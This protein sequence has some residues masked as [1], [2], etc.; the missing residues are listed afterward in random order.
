MTQLTQGNGDALSLSYDQTD[1]LMSAS[2]SAGKRVAYTRSANGRV[3]AKVTHQLDPDTGEEAPETILYSA[4]GWALNEQRVPISQSIAL[5]GGVSL[6]VAADASEEQWQ[7]SSL[8]NNA[9]LTTNGL[10]EVLDELSLYSPYGEVL[11]AHPITMEG[12]PDTGFDGA[13]GV[14]TET[15]AIDINVMGDRVY[16][17]LLHS[18]TTLD[19]TFNGG[20]SP[21][22]YANAD[23]VNLN[24]P[25][26]NAP[27]NRFWKGAFWDVENPYMWILIGGVAMGLFTGGM[28]ALYG[29]NFY[30][31]LAL[32]T[33]IGAIYGFAAGFTY[34]MITTD[35]DW[36]ASLEMG[37]VGA[38]YGAGGAAVGYVLG[39]GAVTAY[40]GNGTRP[41]SSAGE[42]GEMVTGARLWGGEGTGSAPP[43]EA[44][45]APF[46]YAPPP[47]ALVL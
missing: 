15:F 33:S 37:G 26:G 13:S 45:A 19:P 20:T 25:S 21:Y 35:G 38:A 14:E 3:L 18:F 28:F 39:Y 47:A 34:G 7:Y 42:G 22:G 36:K 6:S 2:D 29:V 9:L 44:Y 1:Q 8:Q 16:I 27:E 24:D 32:I 30:M 4:N 40:G 23:P 41:L 12:M 31:G 10:G 46:H 17:P 11:T 43:P 5:P